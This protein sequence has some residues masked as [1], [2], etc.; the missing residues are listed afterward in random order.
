MVVVTRRTLAG[1]KDMKT[2]SLAFI[3]ALILAGCA[4]SDLEMLEVGDG[5]G[6]DGPAD[7]VTP[8]NPTSSNSGWEDSDGDGVVDKFDNCQ[9][10]FNPGQ[11]DTDR[12]GSGDAC[13]NC[14]NTANA[15]QIDSDGNG[16]GDACEDPGAPDA[17]GDGRPDVADNCP[18]VANA[19][20]A[21]GDFDGK[22]DVCDNCPSAANPGQ[23]DDD[24]DGLGNSCDPD[25]AGEI[26]ASEEFRPNVT[27]IEPSFVMMLD[28]SGSMANELDATRPRP[29]PIDTAKDAINTVADNLATEARIGLSQFPFQ[30]SPGSTCTT[31]DHLPVAMNS[32]NSIKNAVAGIQAVGNTP[33]GF[34]L[35]SILDGGLLDDPTDPYNARRPKG[36]ILITDGDP[37]VACDTGS[38]VNLRVEAQPEAVAA[39]TRLKNAGI[40]VYVVGFMSGANPA[41]LDQIAAAGGTD[42]PGANRFYTANNAAD[43]VTVIQKIKEQIV[44]CDYQLANVPADMEKIFVSVDGQPVAEDPANG[45]TF[46]PFAQLVSLH[47]A[48]CDGI[49]NAPDPAQK[50][51]Q[52]DITCIGPDECQPTPEVCDSRDN[53]CDSQ[54][55]EDNVCPGTGG[56]PEVCDGADNDLD[57]QVDEGCPQCQLI[58]D[59]CTT[60]ADCCN[61]DCINGSCTAQCRPNEVACVSNSDCCSGACSGTAASPGVCLAM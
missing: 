17:D 5:S 18:N 53:D 46:D 29:W 43:L 2:R 51:I 10:A 12:D 21:D 14:I 31:K 8:Q 23:S 22:G 30:N 34:A 27:T 59:S 7:T 45:F 42:A 49:K 47:G 58:G 33:T 36:V 37:T 20:Q 28:A 50:R 25:Y 15:D 44:S 1:K 19:D 6:N 38:P 4:Q 9:M 60:S 16:L 3:L 48:A 61:S 55:D 56:N 26:C 35:N 24:A 32:A 39:A 52:V 13:D 54:V 57:G 41:N 11:E 40:P